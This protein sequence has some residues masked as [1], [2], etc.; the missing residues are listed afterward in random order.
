MDMMAR[1]A[2]ITRE[3]GDQGHGEW[4]A[5]DVANA[6]A[7]HMNATCPDVHHWVE[8]KSNQAQAKQ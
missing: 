4:V 6:W 8:M 2:W 5:A 3:T 1:V 7:K